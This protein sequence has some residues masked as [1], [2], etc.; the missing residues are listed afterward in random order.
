M[1]NQV[2][3]KLALCVIAFTGTD[4][5]DHESNKL[6]ILRDALWSIER[7]RLSCQETRV[8]GTKSNAVGVS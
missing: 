1:I 3:E 7:P 8:D 6:M 2:C 4:T 5:V